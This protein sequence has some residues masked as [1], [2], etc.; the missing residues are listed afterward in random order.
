[1]SLP[2][3]CALGASAMKRSMPPHSSP[4]K[5]SSTTYARLAGSSTSPIALRMPS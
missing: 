2:T 4:S 3:S 5:W 1:M